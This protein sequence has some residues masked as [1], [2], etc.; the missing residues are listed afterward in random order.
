MTPPH[1]AQGDVARGFW[2]IGFG[3]LG[4][5]GT[6]AAHGLFNSACVPS[7]ACLQHDVHHVHGRR[8]PRHS[9]ARGS[10][11]HTRHRCRTEL[12]AF[13]PRLASLPRVFAS[14]RRCRCR[15]VLTRIR[16]PSAPYTGPPGCAPEQGG[17]HPRTGA[18][19]ARGDSRRDRARGYRYRGGGCKRR[20]SR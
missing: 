10:R 12:L 15:S 6:D 7:T 2:P 8:G 19:R 11:Q 16:L 9:G 20:G 17:R 13:I 4:I 3:S 18:R 14:F 1:F 5:S